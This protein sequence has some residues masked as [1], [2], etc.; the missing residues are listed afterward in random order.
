MVPSQMRKNPSFRRRLTLTMSLLLVLT[1]SALFIVNYQIERRILTDQIRQRALLIGKTL[2]FNVTQLLPPSSLSDLA[3][4]PET[5]RSEIRNFIRQFGQEEVHLD[6]YSQNEGVHDLF[7]IDVNNRVTIDYPAEKEGRVLPVQERLD[8]GSISAL[9][10]NE[11]LS[12]IRPRGP[13]TILFLTFPVLKGGAVIGFG[14]I[15]MSMNSAVN[16]LDRIKFWAIV[17]AAT[18]FLMAVF[19][20]AYLA[21]TVTRP[22]TE[23][24]QA[25]AR[26]GKGDLTVRL[27]EISQD[28]IGLLK[29]AFNRMVDGIVKLEETES[30]MEKSEMASQLAA[31]MAH[32]IKNP[33]NSIG[34]IVDLMGDRYAPRNEADRM[35]IKKLS[36][37]LKGELARLNQI[38]EGFIGFA[39]PMEVSLKSTDLGELL[40]ETIEFIKPE[41]QVQNVHLHL[42]IDRDLPKILA[43]YGQL[44]HALMN[45]LINAIQ[46][47]PG[48]GDILV[49]G[50]KGPAGIQIAVKDS[51]C[52]IPRENLSKLFDP[53]FTTKIRGFGLG[54]SIVERIVQEHGGSIT[55]DSDIGKGATFTIGL[56]ANAAA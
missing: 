55:V 3:G 9:E 31:R 51:G 11:I 14:R 42:S 15:E 23:L 32:E 22:M 28:E 54:L 21:R 17:S 37:D 7:F 24:V 13:D 26:I 8:R 53:Y 10:H 48:G 45:L 4:I 39:R 16:L 44:R 41:A 6:M 19:F 20:A 18:L 50:Y 38:V 43:D 33:L 30:R 2:Q 5:E 36:D 52:G 46:A 12:Q 49:R 29:I 27:D 1:T 47:M 56:P 34:L 25:A 35:Q 40:K